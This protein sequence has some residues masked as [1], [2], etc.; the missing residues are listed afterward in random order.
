MKKNILVTGGNGQLG[1][2]LSVLS[3]NHPEFNWTFTDRSTLDLSAVDDLNE[4]LALFS[5]DILINCAAYTAVDKAEEETALADKINHQAVGIMSRWSAEHGC[6]FIHI[7]TDYVFDGL[8][9]QALTEEAATNPINVYGSTKLAGEEMCMS[10]NPEA[11]I[12]RTS[13]VYSEFGHNFVK[14]MIKLLRE[15]E[16]LNIV[17]D[18][19]GSPTYARDLANAII[20]IFQQETWQAG[21]YHYSNEGEISWYQ[22]ACDIQEIIGT[23]CRLNGVTTDKYPTPAK[24]PKYSLLN[25]YK[26][27]ST[28]HVEVPNYKSSLIYCLEK[29]TL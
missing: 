13:W 9:S 19:I 29:L 7:S 25:K 21:I 26:I 20:H 5:P 17:N 28:F 22:F 24:R 6:K 12:L 8:S 1:M 11:I 16:E 18:Q 23:Q 3:H 4:K 14:T 10:M 2:E 15:R 27:K